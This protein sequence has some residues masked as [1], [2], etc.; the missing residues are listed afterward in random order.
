MAEIAIEDRYIL[1]RSY[2]KGHEM[3]HHDKTT[4]VGSVFEKPLLHAG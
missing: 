1:S 3:A 2:T 4:A